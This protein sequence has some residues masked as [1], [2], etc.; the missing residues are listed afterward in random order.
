MKLIRIMLQEQNW[1]I[2]LYLIYILSARFQLE[3]WSAQA[4]LGSEPFQLGSVQLGK[5]QL[6]LITTS[7]LLAVGIVSLFAV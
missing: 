1:E 7:Q 4:R 2:L 5:F 6:E 3:Y